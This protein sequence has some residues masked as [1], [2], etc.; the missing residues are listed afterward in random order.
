[1]QSLWWARDRSRRAA[2]L[3]LPACALLQRFGHS[4][5]PETR[6]AA[7]CDRGGRLLAVDGRD[8]GAAGVVRA[9]AVYVAGRRS[10]RILLRQRAGRG[11][12]REPADQARRLLLFEP[13]AAAAEF[14][15][16]LSRLLAR[17]FP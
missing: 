15:G 12:Q 17:A 5:D 8:G 4:P 10:L 11:F 3:L 6:A 16:S 13:V 7:V 14:D 2:D 9:G 1:M